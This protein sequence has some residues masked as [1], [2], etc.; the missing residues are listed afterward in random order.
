MDVFE[1]E[2]AH[3]VWVALDIMMVAGQAEIKTIS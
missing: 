1:F 2:I 3:F